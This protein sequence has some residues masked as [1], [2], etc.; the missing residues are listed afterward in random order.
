MD[1]DVRTGLLVVLA[2]Y[3]SYRAYTW[4]T[5]PTPLALLPGPASPSWLWGHLRVILAAE[6]SVLHEQW[7]REYGP[8]VAYYGIF[9]VSA[10]AR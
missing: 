7:M 1:H 5:R 8:V 3:A 6:H 10:S 9:N 2:A 4:W